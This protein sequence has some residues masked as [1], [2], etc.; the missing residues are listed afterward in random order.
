MKGFEEFKCNCGKEFKD[1]DLW[2]NH[3]HLTGHLIMSEQDLDRLREYVTKIEGKGI[4][5]RN[6]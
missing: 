4:V 1:F 2:F 3:L 6:E 5:Q